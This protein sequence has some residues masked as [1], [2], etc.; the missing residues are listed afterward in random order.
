LIAPFAVLALLDVVNLTTS[1]HLLANLGDGIF[2]DLRYSGM[3]GV[4]LRGFRLQQLPNQIA[5]LLGGEM[6][7]HDVL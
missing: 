2:A 5:L 6:A 1:L 4:R 3:C 7:A